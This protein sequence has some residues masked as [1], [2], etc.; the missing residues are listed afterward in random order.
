MAKMRVDHGPI[1]PDIV[2]DL[3]DAEKDWLRSW[4][5]ESEF[6]TDAG[7]PVVDSLYPNGGLD[8]TDDD[9]DSTPYDDMDVAGLKEELTKR[10][11]PVSGRKPELIERLVADDESVEDDDDDDEDDDDTE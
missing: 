9:D 3:T 4:N 11:L 1:D 7:A 5:R 8:D 10:D 2:G 6:E